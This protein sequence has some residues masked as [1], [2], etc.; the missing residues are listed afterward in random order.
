[1]TYR[2]TIFIS[3]AT[4]QDNEFSIW[5]ASRLEMLG[6]KV[7]IDKNGLLGGERFWP[8]IQKA[9]DRSA[10]ILFVYSKNIINSEGTLKNGIE[11]EIEYG[12][13]IAYE[14]NLKDYLIPLN[15]DGSQYNL[16]IGL[17][18]INHIPFAGNWAKG[19]KQLLK[20]LEK[21]GVPKDGV[22]AQSS[23][24]EWYETVFSSDISIKSCKRLYYSSWWKFKTLPQTFYIFRFHS[25]KQAKLVRDLNSQIPINLNSNILV[26]FERNLTMEI[27]DTSSLLDNNKIIPE[28]IYSCDIDDLNYPEVFKDTFPTHSDTKNAFTRLLM[29]VWNT[30]MRGKGLCKYTLSGKRQAYYRPQ[31]EKAGSTQFTY[32]YSNGKRSKKKSLTGKYKSLKWHYAISGNLLFTPYCCYNVKAHLIF[33]TDGKN[34][35]NDEKKMHSYRRDKAKMFFNEE[36]RD[37]FLA[38]VQ[39]LRDPDGKICIPVTYNN[40]MVELKE[41]P[42]LFWSDFD[43]LDPGTPMSIDSIS[44]YIET[45]E[46]FDSNDD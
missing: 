31:F 35:V 22:H 46:E 17:P 14:N 33:T 24:A 27:T 40:Q 45:P 7:W 2:D 26:T 20:K 25:A 11:S 28:D 29:C 37:L 19:L 1:M 21:D 16:A 39:S 41:W 12:K 6:Y 30:L 42:E 38:M 15:I 8:T 10:K 36:W 23:F 34:P 32:P 3:H 9:I 18:N 4:P 5:L 43:Y 13:S 44:D